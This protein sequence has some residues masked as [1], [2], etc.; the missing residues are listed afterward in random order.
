MKLGRRSSLGWAAE[1]ERDAA[2]AKADPIAQF[3]ALLDEYLVPNKVDL[4]RP[5][6]SECSFKVVSDT[7]QGASDEDPANE[8]PCDQMI[9]L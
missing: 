3:F 2:A 9:I 5:P 7:G 1:I 4:R 8:M 6:C